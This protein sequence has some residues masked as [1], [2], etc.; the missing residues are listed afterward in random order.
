MLQQVESRG[1]ILREGDEAS[2]LCEILSGAVM[3]YRHTVDGSRVILGLRFKGELVGLS[4]RQRYACSAVAIRPTTLR[5]IPYSAIDKAIDHD[6]RLARRLLNACTAELC[7]SR[8]QLMIVGNRTALGRVAALIID[9]ADRS[10]EDGIAMT[11]PFT[12]CEMGDYLG[13]TL[14]TVSRAISRLKALRIIDLPRSDMVIIR[15]RARLEA[16]A[17]GDG[18]GASRGRLCA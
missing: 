8:E 16:L 11:L 15:D 1:H 10:Q 17:D 12:R 6:P 14:E 18:D 5:K 2:A 7:R 13:L 4:S 9:L 3:I